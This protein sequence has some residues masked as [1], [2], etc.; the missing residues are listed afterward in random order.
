MSDKPENEAKK[1]DDIPRE[2]LDLAAAIHD[3]PSEHR[4][5][6]EPAMSR[7]LDSTKRRR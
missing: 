5:V 7:V 2:I 4:E 3:L 1:S 6:L